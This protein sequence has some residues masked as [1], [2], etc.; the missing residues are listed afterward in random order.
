LKLDIYLAGLAIDRRVNQGALLMALAG[1][2]E[3]SELAA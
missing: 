3:I 2:Q 1:D